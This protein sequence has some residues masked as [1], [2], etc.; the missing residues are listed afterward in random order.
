MITHRDRI[1]MCLLVT[2]VTVAGCSRKEETPQPIPIAQQQQQKRPKPEV[3]PTDPL[4]K[5]GRSALSVEA[6]Y[7]SLKTTAVHLNAANAQY[8]LPQDPARIREIRTA[9]YEHNLRQTQVVF[10]GTPGANAPWAPAVRK[11]M[12]AFSRAYSRTSALGYGV[13]YQA[14]QEALEAIDPACDDALIGYW[15]IRHGGKIHALALHQEPEFRHAVEALCAS[16]GYPRFAA[17]AASNYRSRVRTWHEF[18]NSPVTEKELDRAEALYKKALQDFIQ[19]AVLRDWDDLLELA[20]MEIGYQFSQGQDRAKAWAAVEEVLRGMNAPEALRDALA[21]STFIQWAWDARGSGLAHTVT[22]EGFALYHQRLRT[23]ALK[24]EAAWQAEPTWATPATEMLT[25]SRGLSYDREQMELW[26]RRAMDAN[27][28]NYIA[29]M[30]KKEWL[31]PRWHGDAAER[32]AFLIQCA[33]AQ[34]YF[35]MLHLVLEVPQQMWLRFENPEVLKK[36]TSPTAYW[37]YVLTTNEM[38]LNH[39]PNDRWAMTRLAYL[40]MLNEENARHAHHYFQRL[41]GNPWPG[42]FTA[43]EYENAEVEAKKAADLEEARI[44]ELRQQWHEKNRNR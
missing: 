34:N 26:F 6:Y 41:D 22:D 10:D 27:P 16:G 3:D 40:A 25:I 29:C 2:L 42:W 39:Y 24:L 32:G 12:Q 37:F 14:F 44:A 7:S 33:Q 5:P 23:A 1:G 20:Q 15:R 9:K 38:Y 11:A 21:G 43:E 36:M 8:P 35:G 31:D 28:D 18:P 13:Y 19:V 4:G 30:N 17:H